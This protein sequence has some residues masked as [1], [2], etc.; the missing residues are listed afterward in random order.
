MTMPFNTPAH[1]KPP[2]WTFDLFYQA[3]IFTSVALD[4]GGMSGG[5]VT[6]SGSQQERA[7]LVR[8]VV[9]GELI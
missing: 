9:Q 1:Q 4:G 6:M 8:H 7:C 3:D 2:R 5:I